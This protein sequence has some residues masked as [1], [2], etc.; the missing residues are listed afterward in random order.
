MDF[1]LSD[2]VKNL[3]ARLEA[4]MV[5]EVYPAEKTF[6]AQHQAQTD[7]WDIPPV[8]ETLKSRAKAQGLWNFFLTH[9]DRGPRLTNLEYA[10]LCEVMGRSW[11]GPEVFNC[12]APDTGNME[13]LDRYG[14]DAQRET[15]LVPLLDGRIRSAFAMTE[16][17][18]ASSDATNIATSIRRDGDDY[19]VNGRKWWSSGAGDRRCRLLIVMGKSDIEAPAHAQHSMILVPTD[20]PGVSIVRPLPV[21]GYDHAPFGHWEVAFDQVRVPA[22][23]LIL[24]E[25]RGFEI[26][27]G[28]LGPGRIHH[29]MRAIGYAERALDSMIARVKARV[30]FGKPLADQGSIRENIAWSRIEI[31]QARLLV[32]RAAHMMDTVGNKAARSEIAQIKV[33]APHVAERVFSRAI[34]AHGGAGVSDDFGLAHQ[35]SMSRSMRIFDGPDEVHL[36]SIARI[37]LKRETELWTT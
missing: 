35:W 6:A 28:R 16:P 9:S 31:E 19:V 23:N 5:A 8:L 34:Q 18:V 25:G 10:P 13:V 37:E 26:A 14:T 12:A 1:E 32:L 33:L 20:A 15:W 27:Q 21:F 3:K 30:A 36:D 7:R 17:A 2:K 29:A 24:G 11:I 22:S 4:F